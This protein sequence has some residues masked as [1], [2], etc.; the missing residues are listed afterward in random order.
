MMKRKL[1]YHDG[2]GTFF[3]HKHTGLPLTCMGLHWLTENL[4]LKNLETAG[5]NLYLL[6]YLNIPMYGTA[7]T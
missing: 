3:I 7:A 6:V 2:A 5:L 1:T 4:F